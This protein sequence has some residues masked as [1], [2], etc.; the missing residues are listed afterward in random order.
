MSPPGA[1]LDGPAA[2]FA[3]AST[4][5]LRVTTPKKAGHDGRR[6][7]PDTTVTDAHHTSV[8]AYENTSSGLGDRFGNVVCASRIPSRV[9]PHFSS[10]RHDA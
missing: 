4:F 7:K 9:N 10:T 1:V 8:R 6:L 5:A 3:Q 2:A